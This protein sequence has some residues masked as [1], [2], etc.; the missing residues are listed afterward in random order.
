[1]RRESKAL[2]STAVVTGFGYAAQLLSLFAIPLYLRTLGTENYGLMVTVAAFTG[3]LN[4]ADAGLS[5]GTMILIA[6][7]SG[8]QN[9]GEIALVIRHG[10]VLAL[11]SGVVALLALAG[12][13]LLAASGHRLPMFAAHPETDVLLVIA[14]L[15]LFA[16]LQVGTVHSLFIGLQE[17]YWAGLYQGLARILGL[18][19]GMVVAVTTNNVAWVMA[20]QGAVTTLA[21]GAAAFHA[22]RLH[23]WAFERGNWFDKAQYLT[24]LRVG[25]KNFM[26]Q[27]GRTLSGTA[28][29]LAIS[30]IAGPAMVPLYTVPL[31]LFGL[32]LVPVNSW[33]A[34]MQGAY[35]EAWTSGDR[36]WV[37]EAF[38]NSLLRVLVVTGL[39][40]ALF[41]ALGDGFV[42]L[43]THDRL[44]VSLAMAGSVAA[45]VLTGTLL[46]AGQCLLTGLNRHGRISLAEMVNGV[47]A[48]GLVIGSVRWIG[49][50]GAGLGVMLAALLSSAWVL[51]RAVVAQLGPDCFPKSRAVV[52]TV[53]GMVAGCVTAG[54]VMVSVNVRQGTP[55]A[56]ALGLAALA[57]GAVFIGLVLVLRVLPLDLVREAVRSMSRR[58]AIHRK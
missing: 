37:K 5:W 47:L 52:K 17:N 57:G 16:S 58:M 31:T 55:T 29:I 10:A 33:N 43:W 36:Q 48:L 35:G 44:S 9:K 20:W 32:F 18:A 1:M 56:I 4:F 6:H 49:V 39:G 30:S 11:G 38:R 40:L 15:Q 7:A 41:F 12:L 26:L 54:S 23:P 42:R 3:Y 22:W 46:A 45:T 8:R 50:A 25:L 34:N 53:V 51:R 21:G 13:L 27:A 24:Q 28:P 14:G 19:G 2:F